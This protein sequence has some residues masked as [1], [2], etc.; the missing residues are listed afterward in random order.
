MRQKRRNAQVAFVDRNTGKVASMDTRKRLSVAVAKIMPV[1]LATLLVG[2]LFV[3][4][5][6]QAA[7]PG[8]NVT[9]MVEMYNG[10]TKSGDFTIGNNGVVFGPQ[11]G[12]ATIKDGFVINN[13]NNDRKGGVS[14]SSGSAF[15]ARGE[16][17]LAFDNVNIVSSGK[18][19]VFNI[20]ANCSINANN[21]TLNGQNASWGANDPFLLIGGYPQGGAGTL[22]FT[23]TCN[24]FNTT[25][26]IAGGNNNS[27][28]NVNS[29][30]TLTIANSNITLQDGIKFVVKEGA[31]LKFE[32]CTI[33]DDG[34]KVVVESGGTWSLL[35]RPTRRPHP[36]SSCR[37][38]RPSNSPTA[39]NLPPS[40]T[41]ALS[42]SAT[43]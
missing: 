31:T 2:V 13:A 15:I 20:W 38:A 34:I 39:R 37:A 4:H 12:T 1:M 21:T 23:G 18:P 7:I 3:P 36:P 6:A 33:P 41:L 24:I 25:G 22:N 19:L 35:A 27:V 5:M 30:S 26:A 29:G 32:G 8:D 40:P 11:G 16:S 28:I 42:S 10:E 14:T 17:S 43:T 9:A